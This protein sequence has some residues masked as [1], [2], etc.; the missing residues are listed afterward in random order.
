M[1]ANLIGYMV[2][3]P[4]AIDP[5]REGELTRQMMARRETL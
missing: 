1:G 3:G 2:A 4:V 5:T